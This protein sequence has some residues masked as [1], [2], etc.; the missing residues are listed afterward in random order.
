MSM[1]TIVDRINNLSSTLFFLEGHIARLRAQRATAF[2][3]LDQLRGA[4]RFAHENGHKWEGPTREE[5]EA[6]GV[7]FRDAKMDLE[8]AQRDRARFLGDMGEAEAEL[9]QAKLDHKRAARN[10]PL[11]GRPFATL[12]G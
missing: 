4:Q 7:A 3:R 12:L 9:Q 2:F 8:D 10:R 5:L 6:A 1:S 11:T